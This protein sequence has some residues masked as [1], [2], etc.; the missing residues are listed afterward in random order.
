MRR[1]LRCALTRLRPHRP[2][3][4]GFTLVEVVTTVVV[5][6]IVMIPLSAAL[7]LGYRTTFG[8]EERLSRSGDAQ[9]LAAYWPADVQSAD[10]NGVNPIDAAI[11]PLCVG[12]GT[13]LI[14]FAWDL[15]D[16]SGPTVVRYAASGTGS[17][18][19]IV[20]RA[21]IHGGSAASTTVARSFGEAGGGDAESYLAVV[22]GDQTPFCTVTECTI[23]IDGQYDYTITS[24]RRVPGNGSVTLDVPGRPTGVF[25]TP[26]NTQATVHWTAPADDGGSP[27]TGFV[28]EASN[29]ASVAVDDPAATETIFGGL[30][31]GTSYTF[32]VRAKNAV[33]NGPLS[34]P[35]NAVTPGP[36][37]PDPPKIG[38]A[39]PSPT[40]PGRASVTWSLPSGYNDGGSALT[41]FTLHALHPP[42]QPINVDVNDPNA[43]IGQVDGLLN[44]TTYTI[45]VSA[46]NGGSGESALSAESNQ[47]A[48]LPGAPTALNAL[49]G[50]GQT[51]IQ[52]QKPANGDVPFLAAGGF[53]AT[54]TTNDGGPLDT[55]TGSISGNPAPADPASI[56]VTGLVNG[57]TYGC[58]VHAAN[59][60]GA[61]LESNVVTAVPATVPQQTPAPLAT[62][63][64]GLGQVTVSWTAVPN[65]SPAN[66]GSTLTGYRIRWTGPTSGSATVP[67]SPTFYT[68]SGLTPNQAYSFYV[69]AVNAVGVGAEAS[70]GTTPSGLPSV[71]SVSVAAPAV[72][73]QV[74]VNWSMTN[75]GLNITQVVVSCTATGGPTATQ[76][77]TGNPVTTTNATVSFLPV[78]AGGA[79]GKATNCTVTATN[80]NGNSAPATSGVAAQPFGRCIQTATA[81]AYA[82]VGSGGT[83]YGSVTPI[84]TKSRGSIFNGDDRKRL[85]LKF[86]LASCLANPNG[87]AASIRSASVQ[88]NKE[89]GDNNRTMEWRPVNASWAENTITWNNSS[90]LALGSNTNFTS[91]ANGLRSYSSTFGSGL[92]NDVQSWA[93]TPA[94]N[95]GWN[96]RDSQDSAGFLDSQQEINWT[97]R[98]GSAANRPQLTTDYW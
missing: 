7:V 21:C 94:S 47:I 5:L 15:D 62:S 77:F 96:V 31:N 55:R 3:D 82:A 38:T 51:T 46:W 6:G 91:G 41:K 86:D 59:A 63:S 95:N 52:F 61:G 24:R 98:E 32:R 97:S 10:T 40:V 17:N 39:T 19:K 33:G 76:T 4:Q 22:S 12:S 50:Q 48:T 11:Q 2:A 81:D 42:N 93:T 78:S 36:T 37:V 72:S 90:G 88:L 85:F 1:L 80:A 56:V 9:L 83:N 74:T 20:R 64:P 30:T 53:V 25:A 44:G 84:K 79:N 23:G 67:L 54:C 35:S 70:I 29:G 43:T 16:P 45:A 92:T 71:S 34:S 69:A 27:I 75:G 66:G 58:T 87:A 68:V 14:T 73:Q 49:N 60:T 89:G 8:V 13:T 18:S 57:R 26:R 65:T 28:V